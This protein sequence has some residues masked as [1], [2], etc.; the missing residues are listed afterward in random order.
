M[1]E[2]IQFDLPKEERGY[3]IPQ[4]Q[5]KK[6]EKFL[7]E[8]PNRYVD[9]RNFVTEAIRFFLAWETDPPAAHRMMA[10]DFTP[11]L[12]QMAYAKAQK[13]DL[14]MRQTWP[15]LLEERED[16]IEKFL[17]EN[18]SYNIPLFKPPTDAQ[19]KARS[20]KGDLKKLR[21]RDIDAKQFIK[22]IN[23]DTIK[24]KDN[25]KEIKYDGWPLLSSYYSR[26][27]P[28]KVS[29]TA[30]ADLMY[31]RKSEAIRLD[32]GTLADIYD[33][34]EELSANLRE[35]EGEYGIKRSGK[36]S[37]GLPKPYP[38][39]KEMD[40]TQAL[41]EKRWKDR[42][43]GKRSK[44]ENKNTSET[45]EF[46]NGIL[47]A[48]GLAR[49]FYDKDKKKVY[50]TLTAKGK[51][52]YLLDNSLLWDI[53]EK[54][55]IYDAEY[56]GTF[57]SDERKF[58]LGEI[59]PGLA[60][61]ME[62]VKTAIKT[63]DGLGGKSLTDHAAMLDKEFLH[64][65]E[66]FVGNEKA[67]YR[68]KIQRDIIKKTAEELEKNASAMTPIKAHRVAT[69]GRLSEMGLVA[70]KIIPVENIDTGKVDAKSSYEIMDKKMAEA[71]LK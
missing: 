32:E 1:A 27:F 18:P 38:D 14:M 35:K 16:E 28:A 68:D 12:K 53:P 58:L 69:M 43:I 6:I 48:L 71:I 8:N 19:E 67:P 56:S 49:A 5:S 33:I 40:A 21:D 4:L 60:L 51:K 2:E 45:K 7:R 42:F 36:Y 11:M 9:A 30:I 23:F 61:E 66:K 50:L 46:F 20:S 57:E 15:G 44:S 25:Q 63:I 62:L 64:T 24:E 3:E 59:I 54:Y 13:M 31:Q 34:A 29:I 17:A 55:T 65:V 22:K 37:T 26:L 52:F 39:G 47:S 10:E 70:W 41:S